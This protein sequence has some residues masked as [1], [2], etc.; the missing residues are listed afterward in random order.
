MLFDNGSGLDCGWYVVNGSEQDGN[1]RS[2]Y[3]E[4]EGTDCEDGVSHTDWYR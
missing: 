3:V 4:G 1:F 2:V